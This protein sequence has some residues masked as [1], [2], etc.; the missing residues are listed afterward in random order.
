MGTLYP[1][2]L[3]STDAT[4]GQGS[5]LSYANYLIFT[6]FSLLASVACD[7][8]ASLLLHMLSTQKY[9][10]SAV[11]CL[12]IVINMHRNYTEVLNI[13]HCFAY[14]LDALAGGGTNELQAQ[15]GLLDLLQ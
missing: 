10:K 6:S 2:Y 12:I 5:P 11:A 8:V 13:L 7:Q 9:S 4:K 3:E 14:S 15:V 1:R